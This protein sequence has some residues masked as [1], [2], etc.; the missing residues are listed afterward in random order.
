MAD[1]VYER[2]VGILDETFR[3]EPELI[4]FD[5]TLADLEFDSLAVAELAAIVQEQFGVELGTKDVGK[6]ATLG[7]VARIIGGRTST[8]VARA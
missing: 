2:L 7:E 6:E 4:R 3:V 1:V 8:V 5:A